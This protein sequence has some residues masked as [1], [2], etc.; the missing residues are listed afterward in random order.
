MKTTEFTRKLIADGKIVPSVIPNV[1]RGSYRT[2]G[3]GAKALA[4]QYGIKVST[5]NHYG[6]ARFLVASEEERQRVVTCARKKPYIIKK[7]FLSAESHSAK[8]SACP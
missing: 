6:I 4:V 2:L 5:I 3:P 8:R 7:K 1:N